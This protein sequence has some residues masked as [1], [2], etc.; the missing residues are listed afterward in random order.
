MIPPRMH[1]T[2]RA[3]RIFEEIVS[4]TVDDVIWLNRELRRLLNDEDEGDAGVREP[5]RPL[6]ESPGDELALE[7]HRDS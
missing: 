4:L 5:R 1:P 7:E 2:P 3:Q 6:P